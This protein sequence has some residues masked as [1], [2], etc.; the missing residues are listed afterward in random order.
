MIDKYSFKMD[1]DKM[2]S[3]NFK[4]KK[5]KCK[6]GSDEILL[7][8]LFVS[9]KLQAIRTHFGKSVKIIQLIEQFIIIKKKIGCAK[10]S[11]CT[12]GMAF[13]IVIS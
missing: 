9:E 8:S 2:I 12:K 1:G 7:D 13:D 6:D 5:F 4:V 11:Y 3:P 10:N